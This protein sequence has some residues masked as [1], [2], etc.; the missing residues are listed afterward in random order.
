MKSSFDFL[1]RTS[2]ALRNDD[3][4]DWLLSNHPLQHP[5]K[6]S[7][8]CDVF[9][10]TPESKLS[11]DEMLAIKSPDVPECPNEILMGILAREPFGLPAAPFFHA[12]EN[13]VR[14]SLKV[15]SAHSVYQALK[16]VVLRD[17]I[18]FMYRRAADMCRQTLTLECA[19]ARLDQP[20]LNWENYISNLATFENITQLLG[21][22]PVL[23]EILN[24]FAKQQEI[25]FSRL[26]DR[27]ICD[28]D[29]MPEKSPITAV[30]FGEGDLHNDGQSVIILTFTGGRKIVYKPRN[31]GIEAAFNDALGRLNEA[32]PTVRYRQIL[33]QPRGE[34]G[35]VEFVEPDQCKNLQEVKNFYRAEGGLIALMHLIGGFDFHNENLIASG[36]NP[37]VVDLE[38]LFVANNYS[39]FEGRDDPFN[40]TARYPAVDALFNSV[41]TTLLLPQNARGETIS[42]IAG[43]E[44]QFG[45]NK[46]FDEA[47]Q[48]I[49]RKSQARAALQN[50][51]RLN[52]KRIAPEGHIDDIAEGYEEVYRYLMRQEN[53]LAEVADHMARVVL[54]DT[55]AYAKL[56]EES[57]HPT[58]LQDIGAR[59]AHFLNFWNAT[60]AKPSTAML[61]AE[62]IRQ[63]WNGDV[64]YFCYDPHGTKV[65]R[66]DGTAM[67]YAFKD[68]GF[69]S[70]QKRLAGLGE[71]DLALQTWIIR[72]SLDRSGVQA[73]KAYS[74]QPGEIEGSLEGALGATYNK[75][76]LMSQDN[77]EFLDWLSCTAADDDSLII[78][79]VDLTFYG[80][81]A[82]IIL[83]L[84][85]NA[86]H[87]EDAVARMNA[88]R[89]FANFEEQIVEDGDALAASGAL[90]GQGGLAYL[91]LHLG[92]L[93]DRP[94]LLDRAHEHLATAASSLTSD[95]FDV[96]SGS[97][98]LVLVA[99]AA[100]ESTGQARFLD[101]AKGFG[102]R[103]QAQG[104][105][106]ANGPYWG[107][108]KTEHP[109]VGFAHGA[110]GVILAVARLYQH[111]KDP[112]LRDLVNRVID[113][114]NRDF[115]PKVGNWTDWRWVNAEGGPPSFEHFWCNGSAGIAMTRMALID[116]GWQHPDLMRD[117]TAA[118]QTTARKG[119]GHNLSL[120]HGDIG[121]LD[122]LRR[123]AAM[124]D[125]ADL[126]ETNELK[127]ARALSEI[128]AGRFPGGLVQTVISMGLMV[129]IS[130]IG[131]GILRLLSPDTTPD[132]LMLQGPVRKK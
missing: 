67:E 92:V 101:Q 41:M 47:K 78:A 117:L 49:V 5:D 125:D 70:Y 118:A 9:A 91:L 86:A 63:L 115:D 131:Y 43:A 54:R 7:F 116:M 55:S 123:A 18:E 106:D 65:F 33:I 13:R 85:Y 10:N 57:F 132:I 14:S 102:N 50:Q 59:A 94:E 124:L 71:K 69:D 119:I 19:I 24:R 44:I 38:T 27:I 96:L 105:E 99:L 60:Y 90:D 77:S 103:L 98:G 40:K 89:A 26:L 68:S 11:L 110:S 4:P 76:M 62:E 109:L 108:L 79:P 74:E 56:I 129:G 107:A 122:I 130:G 1:N 52:G 128:A 83:F 75:L 72:S 36:P 95:A 2:E 32:L 120:C 66:S 37:V 23:S 28:Y 80:G 16:D 127:L 30:S 87:S 61:F 34:Y 93:W 3:A 111:T 20:T 97:A 21:E 46:I 81:I 35:W 64:P 17:W 39:S 45:E 22:Y 126:R 48:Q 53:P 88:E 100:F 58:L 104:R 84:A 73:Q 121:N 8:F 113:R 25:V 31:L 29:L 51:P 82:G 12:A 114:E 42:G 6:Q 15:H 112:V